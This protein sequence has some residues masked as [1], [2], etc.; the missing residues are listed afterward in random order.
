MG[1]YAADELH[2]LQLRSWRIGQRA[3]RRDQHQA[4]SEVA[5]GELV[6][7]SDY[8]LLGCSAARRRP[9]CE[10]RL[11]DVVWHLRSII[12]GVEH[13]SAFITTVLHAPAMHRV[14]C[15]DQHTRARALALLVLLF[16][17]ADECLAY[18]CCLNSSTRDTPPDTSLM[19]GCTSRAPRGLTVRAQ[20]Q[21]LVLRNAHSDRP[22]RATRAVRER[23]MAARR[24]GYERRTDLHQAHPLPP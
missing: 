3:R 22:L 23:T 9:C 19:Q 18:K 5:F 24:Q 15:Q 21:R 7:G 13:L 12:A 17:A 20:R 6:S 11:D 14:R 10:C 16:A 8:Q 4:A 1:V 2:L